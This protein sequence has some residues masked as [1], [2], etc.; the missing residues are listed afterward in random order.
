M[1]QDSSKTLVSNFTLLNTEG[2]VQPSRKRIFKGNPAGLKQ[3]GRQ[4]TGVP[5]EE[6]PQQLTDR[7]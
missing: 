6:A 7:W 4:P 1:L 5:S 2:R 3:A